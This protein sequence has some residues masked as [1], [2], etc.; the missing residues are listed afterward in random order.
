VAAG[1]VIPADARLVVTEGNYLALNDSGWQ[2]VRSLIDRLFYLDCPPE[3]RR[4]RLIERHIA[5]GRSR[6]DAVAWVTRVDEP[7]AALVA[8]TR[9][10]C[11]RLLHTDD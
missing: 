2:G 6:D 4:Q 11:D 3:V 10:G 1:L 5:G 7:N 8:A 9:G